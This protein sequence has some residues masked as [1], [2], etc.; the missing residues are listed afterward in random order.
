M[1][2]RCYGS[3]PVS[4]RYAIAKEVH[5]GHPDDLIGVPGFWLRSDNLRSITG[6]AGLAIPCRD[7]TGN[8]RGIRLRPDDPG[9]GGKYRWLSS[10]GKH[11]GAGSGVHCHVARPISG[12]KTSSE[13]WV[14]E[15]ELKADFAAEV[16]AIAV[17]SIPGVASW[18]RAIPDVTSLLPQGG[19][20]VIAMDADWR[21]NAQVHA[22][23]WGLIQVSGA[24]GFEVGVALWDGEA[25]GLDDLLRTGRTP[26]I[27]PPTAL[28]EPPWS[29]KMKVS[30]RILLGD[31]GPTRNQGA[32]TLVKARERLAEVF[33]DSQ[34]WCA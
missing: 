12:S 7:P 1:A 24:L 26:E 8:L 28:P 33:S 14:T 5:N 4:R 19:R 29:A 30:S 9:D 16:L 22:A 13:T 31:A 21:V 23:V 34:S 3:L 15:G 27:L 32:I 11:K 18:A 25:K 2:A 20:V 17:V 6:K 10:A